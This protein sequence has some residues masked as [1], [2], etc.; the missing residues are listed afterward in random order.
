MSATRPR[1][2]SGPATIFAPTEEAFGQLPEGTLAALLED[3]DALAGILRY[4][5]VCGSALTSDLLSTTWV[6]TLS[7]FSLRV[8]LEEEGRIIVSNGEVGEAFDLSANDG[9]VVVHTVNAV[10]LPPSLAAA[11]GF[12]SSLSTLLGALPS[13]VAAMLSGGN[14]MEWTLFAPNNDAFGAL[15]AEEATRLLGDN[16]GTTLYYHLL[17]SKNGRDCLPSGP[18][19]TFTGLDVLVENG[20]EEQRVGRARFV[21]QEIMTTNGVI[22]I[23][24]QVLMPPTIMDM[25]A[26]VSETPYYQLYGALNF[27]ALVGAIQAAGLADALSTGD[28]TLFAPSDDA[29]AQLEAVPSGEA[30]VDLL[31]YHALPNLIVKS[32]ALQSGE[33]TMA[34]GDT[35]SVDTSSADFSLYHTPFPHAQSATINGVTLFWT[36]IPAVNGVIH[37][38][39]GI[40]VPP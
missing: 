25:L 39:T 38:V 31:L 9:A 12:D 28:F 7:G 37:Q 18:V 27:S 34:N 15:T 24:D 26:M 40:L 21:G 32:A 2:T 6:D 5:V 10:L 1:N 17:K 30:L 14:G 19:T 16:T 3:T 22:H 4:H 29:F 23:I 13:S 8:D 11:A 33:I 20:E 36:D 35:A